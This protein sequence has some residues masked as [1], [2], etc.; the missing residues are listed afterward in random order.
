MTDP[1]PPMSTHETLQ[2]T[3]PGTVEVKHEAFLQQDG[4]AIIKLTS[5]P[6]PKK[7]EWCVVLAWNE[8]NGMVTAQKIAE[9]ARVGKA[10]V[11]VGG[12][13]SNSTA[14]AWKVFFVVEGKTE[15]AETTEGSYQNVF[16][17]PDGE[18]YRG[19]TA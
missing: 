7:G 10:T 4:G 18:P 14:P 13:N 15:T 1:T 16:L 6:S 8:E 9:I 12:P 19:E 17:F 11:S 3:F 5:G 2:K